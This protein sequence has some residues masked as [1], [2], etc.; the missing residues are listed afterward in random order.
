MQD[1][2]PVYTVFMSFHARDKEDAEDFEAICG[3]DAD[4]ALDFDSIFETDNRTLDPS[5]FGRS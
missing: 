4:G 2:Y 1:D 5:C 3:E